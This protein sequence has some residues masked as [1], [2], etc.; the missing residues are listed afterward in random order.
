MAI[1][2]DKCLYRWYLAVLDRTLHNKLR[3]RRQGCARVVRRVFFDAIE[4]ATQFWHSRP[5]FRRMER[6]AKVNTKCVSHIE[7]RN[8]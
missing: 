2:T 4:E 5:S 8:R 3:I 7:V 1:E 6:H